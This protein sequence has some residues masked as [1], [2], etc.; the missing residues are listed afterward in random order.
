MSTASVLVSANDSATSTDVNDATDTSKLSTGV[1][2]AIVGGVIVLITLIIISIWWSVRTKHNVAIQ[3]QLSGISRGS[4]PYGGGK[5]LN[6]IW[7]KIK[8]LFY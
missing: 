4:Q 2:A 8:K 1:I 6:K 5:I 3:S 7:K